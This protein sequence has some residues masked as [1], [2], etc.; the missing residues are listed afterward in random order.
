M[1]DISVQIN[2]LKNCSSELHNY[3]NTLLSIQARILNVSNTLMLQSS[4]QVQI[5]RQLRDLSKNVG[6]VSTKM[7][8]MGTSLNSAATAYWKAEDKLLQN[9]YT[10]NRIAK[11]VGGAAG[12][13]IGSS[14]GA[15][16]TY[17]GTK[18]GKEVG[19]IAWNAL[20]KQISSKEPI[21]WPSE[22]KK[23]ALKVGS[24]A[25][26]LGGSAAGIYQLLVDGIMG[27]S[28]KDVYKGGKTIFDSITGAVKA[29]NST[30]G[31]KATWGEAILGLNKPLSKFA[32]AGN[33]WTGAKTAFSETL[34]GKFDV[35]AE[36]LGWA[37]T[38][39]GSG[40]DNAEEFGSEWYKNPRFW[41]ETVGESAVSIAEGALVSSAVAAGLVA[42]G[43]VGAPAIAVGAITVGVTWGLDLLCKKVTGQGVAETVSD[44]V[45]DS[46]IGIW[47][48][49]TEVG[50]AIGDSVGKTAKAVS[51]GVSSLWNGAKR[52]FSFA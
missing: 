45:I 24:K 38:V 9:K 6:T 11:T 51:N 43:W 19:E 29:V 41:A 31:T 15:L 8:K 48:K 1:A 25:G 30:K 37:L 14:G 49:T 10:G 23:T 2:Q 12:A 32:G 42:V 17:V 16:G 22:W 18:I 5:K 27:G 26:L 36:G 34:K 47:D 13:V 21:D 52:M 44:F 46:A 7:R 50:K 39:V 3:S 28:A 4:S 20:Y 40:F 33:G 35:K